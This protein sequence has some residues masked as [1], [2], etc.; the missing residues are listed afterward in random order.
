LTVLLDVQNM[1]RF[2]LEWLQEV[3]QGEFIMSGWLCDPQRRK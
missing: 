1:E 2:C 3:Q